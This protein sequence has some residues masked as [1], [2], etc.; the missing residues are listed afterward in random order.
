MS[1][2]SAVAFSCATL[3]WAN[4]GSGWQGEA[5]G[6]DAIEAGE[7]L[8]TISKHDLLRGDSWAADGLSDLSPLDRL[9]AVV[10]KKKATDGEL[11]RWVDESHPYADD[12]AIRDFVTRKNKKP[13]PVPF[14]TF[15]AL[16][17]SAIRAQREY[18]EVAASAHFEPLFGSISAKE[19]LNTRA[20]VVAHSWVVQGE[21]LLIPFF[22]APHDA[23]VRNVRLAFTDGG[24]VAASATKDATELTMTERLLRYKTFDSE[25]AKDSDCYDISLKERWGNK[26]AKAPKDL[27]YSI[28]VRPGVDE[29]PEELVRSV[30]LSTMADSK[31]ALGCHKKPSALEMFRCV[32]SEDFEKKVFKK[33]GLFLKNEVGRIFGE[34]DIN[35]KVASAPVLARHAASQKE[36]ASNLQKVLYAR[37]DNIDSE[38]YKEIKAEREAIR[39]AKEEEKAKKEEERK[40]KKKANKKKKKKKDKEEKKE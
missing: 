9:I 19:Y 35:E 33:A 12:E 36:I 37:A 14:K 20:F 7:Q 29:A 31:M 18:D 21:P 1:F 10:H 38:M 6:A 13:S 24:D 22:Q 2:L 39:K 34:H 27:P 4:W 28:C 15:F 11:R 5:P 3:G 30:G 16:R 40:A 26:E 17:N 8:F 32:G 23:A 25:A